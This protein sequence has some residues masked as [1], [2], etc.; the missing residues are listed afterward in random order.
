M[1][2]YASTYRPI[3]VTGGAVNCGSSEPKPIVVD[4]VEMSGNLYPISAFVF[5]PTQFQQTVS[6]GGTLLTL[7]FQ[8]DDAIGLSFFTNGT[9]SPVN[10]N[11]F[12]G[13]WF[14]YLG[15]VSF[16]TCVLRSGLDKILSL[17]EKAADVAT[18]NY[19][20]FKKFFSFPDLE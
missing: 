13:S 15:G 10:K 5:S 8:N 6:A 3:Y 2:R 7:A 18:A 12:A 14:L 9:G 1:P 16:A 19:V 17:E 4:A 20:C 11:V